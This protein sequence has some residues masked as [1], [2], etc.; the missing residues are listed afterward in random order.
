ML[1]NTLYIE[2]LNGPSQDDE[3]FAECFSVEKR[4]N[5]YR[6]L[7]E[8]VKVSSGRDHYEGFVLFEYDNGI[9]LIERFFLNKEKG[10]F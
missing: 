4:A 7:G 3:E 6:Q 5:A 8:I 2:I 10:I 9:I 1:V